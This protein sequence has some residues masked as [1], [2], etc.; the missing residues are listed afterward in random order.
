MFSSIPDISIKLKKNIPVGAGL[1]GGSSNVAGLI[2]LLD[3][4]YDLKL[5]DRQKIKIAKRF[6]SDVP[7]FMQGGLAFVEGTG[8]KVKPL[9]FNFHKPLLLVYPDEHISTS[10]AYREHLEL[11]DLDVSDDFFRLKKELLLLSEK[12][13]LTS[14]NE[15][16]MNKLFLDKLFN[17]FQK[18]TLQKYPKFRE[19]FN[20]VLEKTSHILLS[21]SG[22]AFFSFFNDIIT[23]DL[24]YEQLRTKTKFVYKLD[25]F[26]GG[27]V[28]E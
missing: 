14:L 20:I 7:F 21:G 19:L 8:E 17:G 3:R 26:S 5:S 2:V 18:K 22:S 27:V 10:L 1:G 15:E 4:L 28:L 16:E 25:L 9:P 12:G 11:N 13:K 24:V 6:G 23:M